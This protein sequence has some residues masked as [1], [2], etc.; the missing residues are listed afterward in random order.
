MDA[1]RPIRCGAPGSAPRCFVEVVGVSDDTARALGKGLG[2]RTRPMG[3]IGT[4]ARKPRSFDLFSSAVLSLR[5]V[6]ATLKKFKAI[7]RGAS[8]RHCGQPMSCRVRSR[9]AGDPNSPTGSIWRGVAQYAV[10]VQSNQ[11]L[12]APSS[13]RPSIAASQTSC[14]RNSMRQPR[15]RSRSNEFDLRSERLFAKPL[16]VAGSGLTWSCDYGS[17]LAGQCS[18]LNRKCVRR[19]RSV[20]A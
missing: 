4:Q 20:K 19:D 15:H 12:G 9:W 14:V 7:R 1:R 2:R 16:S 11:S 6:I 13:A 18:H 17:T 10:P 3:H 8:P 5:R